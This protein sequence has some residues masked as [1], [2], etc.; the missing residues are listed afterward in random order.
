[1]DLVNKYLGYLVYTFILPIRE[2]LYMG[3]F[4]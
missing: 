1:M 4:H 2:D 3:L